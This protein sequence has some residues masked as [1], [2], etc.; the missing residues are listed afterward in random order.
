MQRVSCLL[1]MP[2]LFLLASS[3]RGQAGATFREPTLLD[4]IERGDW[5]WSMEFPRQESV[6]LGYGIGLKEAIREHCATFRISDDERWFSGSWI[7]A[8]LQREGRVGPDL[9]SVVLSSAQAS[10]AKAFGESDAQR[11]VAEGCTASRTIRV[12][13]NASRM[14][15]G[16]RPAHGAPSGGVTLIDEKQTP[17]DG[18][19]FSDRSADLVLVAQLAQLFEAHAR[20][21]ASRGFQ[22]LECHYDSDPTDANAEV[23]YY[24]GGKQGLFAQIVG[25]LPELVRTAQQQLEARARE[26]G[27][28]FRTVPRH[29]FVDYAYPRSECPSRRDPSLPIKQIAAYRR[30]APGVAAPSKPVQPIISYPYGNHIDFDFGSVADDF[31]PTVPLDTLPRSTLHLRMKKSAAL[32]LTRIDRGLYNAVHDIPLAGR[33]YYTRRELMQRVNDDEGAVSAQGGRVLKCYYTTERQSSMAYFALYWY[34]SRPPAADRSRLR[35]RV[36][37]HPYLDIRAPRRSCP[38]TW[39]AARAAGFEGGNTRVVTLPA[40]EPNRPRPPVFN[41]RDHQL[42]IH[43]GE[44]PDS[45]FVPSVPLDTAMDRSLLITWVSNKDGRREQRMIERSRPN[46]NEAGAALRL[47]DDAHLLICGYGSVRVSFWFQK[48]PPSATPEKLRELP[49][50]HPFLTIGPPREN[51]PVNAGEARAAVTRGR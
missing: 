17:V 12:F 33:S 14:T 15:S 38:P 50:G 3:A 18:R 6:L 28:A 49:E 21:M 13:E 9:T 19:H 41:S 32:V 5:V 51:C 47:Q 44:Q 7:L 45:N 25:F 2:L 20:D 10:G 11:L 8:G 27:V 16:R 37:D 23:Q 46:G 4:R 42:A 43:Y 34:D 35:A 29:P 22:V 30:A 1:I 24:W 36:A 26:T 40:P 39:D 31:T 48:L